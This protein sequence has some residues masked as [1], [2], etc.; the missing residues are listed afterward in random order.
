M[1][2][3]K[4]TTTVLLI[5]LFF[6]CGM[7]GFPLE[8]V[9]VWVCTCIIHSIVCSPVHQPGDSL[10]RT[11]PLH[12]IFETKAHIQIVCSGYVIASIKM[13]MQSTVVRQAG[14]RQ[15]DRQE[16]QQ[17][18]REIRGTCGSYTH[19]HTV[20]LTVYT[21]HSGR[22]GEFLFVNNYYEMASHGA[23]ASPCSAWWQVCPGTPQHM[24][25]H[26]HT[27][28]STRTH[29]REHTVSL[30][31]SPLLSLL[32]HSWKYLLDPRGSQ[33]TFPSVRSHPHWVS[34]CLESPRL[35]SRPALVLILPK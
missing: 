28:T 2:S 13:I 19:T 17:S 16:D 5:V 11:R 7:N 10:W 15:T 14:D 31:L 26:A 8:L 21:Q 9:C 3:H 35:Q 6:S 25:R 29:T 23:L 33:R 4:S 34:Q 12:Y 22:Q 27:S 32:L 1:I 24:H 18:D 30:F 20:I